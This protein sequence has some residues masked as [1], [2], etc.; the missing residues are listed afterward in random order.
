MAT[1]SVFDKSVKTSELLSPVKVLMSY[2]PEPNSMEALLAF[3]VP[4]EEDVSVPPVT[5]KTVFSAKLLVPVLLIVLVVIWPALLMFKIE[6]SFIVIPF[7]SPVI[8][9]S[10]VI[11]SGR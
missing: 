11:V 1:V 2:E 8:K 10:P 5:V 3:T 9:A 7:E 6:S 4:N